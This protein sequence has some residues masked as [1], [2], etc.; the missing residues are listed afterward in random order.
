MSAPS[1]QAHEPAPAATADSTAQAAPPPTPA[2]S[3]RILDH[4]NF[5]AVWLGQFLSAVGA[6]MTAFSLSIWVFQG[7][8]SVAQYGL[9]VAAQMLPA[10]LFA[11]PAGVLADRYDRRKIMLVCKIA[12]ALVALATFLLL[13]AGVLTPATIGLATVAASIFATVHQIAYAASVPLLVPRSMYQ[14]AN[15][16]VQ[17]SI[18][19][20]AVVVPLVAV[21][22]L[23][24][25]GIGRVILVEFVCALLAV[26]SLLFARFGAL[27][28]PAPGTAAKPKPGL[29]QMWAEQSFGLRYVFARPSLA[30]LMGYL[31]AASFVNGFVYVLFRPLMLT[32]AD[33]DTLGL[34]VTIAG[35]GGLSGAIFVGFLARL[36][37]RISLLLWFSLV[38]GL[39]MVLCGA[40]SSVIWIGVA[41]FGFSFSI[42]VAV[43]AVQTLLQ[44]TIPPQVQGRVFSARALLASG[45]LLVAVLVSPI[46][47]ELCFEPWLLE[48]GALAPSVGAVFGV[49]PGRGIAVLFVIAG[50]AMMAVSLLAGR[51]ASLR[52]LRSGEGE[53]EHSAEA[54]TAAANP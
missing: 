42:P 35:V 39:C 41:A 43:V 48:G 33:A 1:T 4:K 22:V 7:T 45:S 6:Q 53:G 28:A 21:L 36:R 3:R 14:K 5:L 24:W 26:A 20:S 46:L 50:V 30:V 16:L 23:Q 15:G 13:G 12:G 51:S 44:E 10:V 25:L 8:G 52:K 9:V 49:G 19:V 17:T 34:L 2:Q 31:A 40:T 47:A 29:A 38:S 54:T 27:P 11:T 37:D 32:L 18:H